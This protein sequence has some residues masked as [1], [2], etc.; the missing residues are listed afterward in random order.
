MVALLNASME[1]YDPSRLS[2]RANAFSVESL[3]ST[4]EYNGYANQPAAFETCMY[5]C[6]LY[7]CVDVI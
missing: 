5:K 6:I 2:S 1:A 3:V 7:N 4:E